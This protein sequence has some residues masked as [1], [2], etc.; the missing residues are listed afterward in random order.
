MALRGFLRNTLR[1]VRKPEMA[2]KG[3]KAEPMSKDRFHT[4]RI[5]K[6]YCTTIHEYHVI[7]LCIVALLN[8]TGWG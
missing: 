4:A 5:S 6:T 3:Q 2:E 7:H 1:R 8:I